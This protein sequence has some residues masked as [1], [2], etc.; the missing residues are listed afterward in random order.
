MTFD[1]REA[2][3]DDADAISGVILAALR[4]SN[5]RDY[6]R[7]V[8]DRVERSFSPSAV[9][10]LLKTRR[11]FVAI[12]SGWIV[13]TASLEGTTV[14]SVFVHPWRQRCGIGKRLM[15]EIE[16]VVRE[17]GASVLTVPSSVTAQAF[18]AGLGFKLVGDSYFGEER[19]IIMECQL[20]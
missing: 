7:D 9:V 16:K 6:P 10:W 19:T 13:G 4:T 11:V 1:I 14:R 17:A 20:G 15:A 5:S 12:M 18:Y 3:E 2:R 8:I